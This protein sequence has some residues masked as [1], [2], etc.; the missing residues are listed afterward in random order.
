MQN[1]LYLMR[2]RNTTIDTHTTITAV[3]SQQLWIMKWSNA[4]LRDGIVNNVIVAL[5]KNINT[6][7]MATVT[8]EVKLQLQRPTMVLGQILFY[9]FYS[10]QILPKEAADIFA[11]V[12]Y[13]YL[14]IHFRPIL[15]P[16]YYLI[17]S[18][19]PSLHYYRSKLYPP[20][21]QRHLVTKSPSGVPLCSH[22]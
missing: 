4:L 17:P 13:I 3:S 22:S 2:A 7:R 10:T 15:I 1:V 5:N 6:L 20:F 14:Y 8:P 12:R 11:Q 9:V 16:V 21:S 19:L 18:I